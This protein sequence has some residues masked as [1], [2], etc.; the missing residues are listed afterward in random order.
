M[1]LFARLKVEAAMVAPSAL[2]LSLTAA[3]I[4][5]ARELADLTGLLCEN[6]VVQAAHAIIRVAR[7]R[8]LR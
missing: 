2:G 6:P 3:D 1:I 7:K 8:I 4:T 5:T